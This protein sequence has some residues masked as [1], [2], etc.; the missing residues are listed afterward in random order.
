M[1]DPERVM[2]ELGLACFCLE[3]MESSHWDWDFLTGNAKKKCQK[4]K[5]GMRFEHC[6]VVFQNGSPLLWDLN[7]L[8]VINI[9][10]VTFIV[11][12]DRTIKC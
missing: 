11:K 10:S 3:K 9:V 4:S 12:L 2:W 8:A 7:Q 1:K 6:E 5:M